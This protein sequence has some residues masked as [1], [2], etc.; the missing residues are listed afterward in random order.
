MVSDTAVAA[1]L[2]EGFDKR[3]REPVR[4]ASIVFAKPVLRRYVKSFIHGYASGRAG[5]YSATLARRLGP[6]HSKRP[7]HFRSSGCSS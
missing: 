1:D 2:Q 6:N 7:N 3:P 5:L 4:S